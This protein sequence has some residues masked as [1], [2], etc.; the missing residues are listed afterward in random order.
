MCISAAG[1]YLILLC[2]S[3]T[4]M[5]YIEWV[6]FSYFVQQAIA[7]GAT[8]SLTS[9]KWD[10]SGGCSNPYT[11]ALAS[12]TSP[13]AHTVRVDIPDKGVRWIDIE[14]PCRKCDRC[15]RNRRNL[16]RRRMIHEVKQS[17]RVWFGTLTINPHH[18]FIF[19]LRAG[20]RDYIASHQ[21]ISK[22]LTKYF[23]RLRK[24]GY[25]FRYCVVAEAHKD[26][27]PHLHMLVH[28]VSAPI[29]KSRLQA[30]WPFGF[31][32]FKLVKD[33][34]AVHYVAKYLAK[35]ARTRIRASL[36][37][38]QSVRDLYSEIMDH[39]NA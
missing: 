5:K 39:L 8:P 29:P 10:V 23:K 9:V 4:T 31:T 1:G 18:R 17:N 21:E 19:S 37:Y 30:E 12:G 2:T 28:E 13:D 7:S 24:A 11:I 14:T 35:D 34:D 25:I 36:R 6:K 26:G 3:D 20:S 22:E 27:Y 32:T 15:L 16:W 38:G 33:F